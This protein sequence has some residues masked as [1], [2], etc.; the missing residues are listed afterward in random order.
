M[1]N[2]D[3]L[4]KLN[5]LEGL[6]QNIKIGLSRKERIIYEAL[7]E[8]LHKFSAF[9]LQQFQKDMEEFKKTDS[10]NEEIYPESILNIDYNDDNVDI[11]SISDYETDTDDEEYKES[12]KNLKEYDDNICNKLYNMLIVERYFEI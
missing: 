7:I 6:L 4:I 1:N 2:T 10:D 3:I 9:S 11:A 8:R 5:E 12:E